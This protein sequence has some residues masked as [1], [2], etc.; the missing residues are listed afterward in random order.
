MFFCTIYLA[1]LIFNNFHLLILAHAGD[2]M[3]TEL[4]VELWHS[5][6]DRVRKSPIEMFEGGVSQSPSKMEASFKTWLLGQN[7]SNR[8]GNSIG[9]AA[10]HAAFH[11]SHRD[12][13]WCVPHSPLLYTFAL[14]VVVAQRWPS[15]YLLLLLSSLLK[16]TH[17]LSSFPFQF[18]IFHLL[19]WGGGEFGAHVEKKV[20]LKF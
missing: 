1:N 11:A 10:A 17:F 5:F 9:S 19:F 2:I 8:Y 7:H 13:L 3:A 20:A 4:I 14:W 16:I 12:H 15:S 18:S 6:N